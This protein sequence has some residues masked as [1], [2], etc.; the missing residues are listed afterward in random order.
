MLEELYKQTRYKRSTG[1]EYQMVYHWRRQDSELWALTRERIWK[2]DQGVCQSPS[3]APPKQHKLC[4]K[5]VLLKNCHIDHIQPLSSGGSNHARN[6]RTL[7]SVCHAL[8]LDR[9]HRALTTQQVSQ[10]RLPINWK[11]LTWM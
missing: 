3:G 2:R 5:T 11:H 10:G 4:S 6:L 1:L 9:K 8:R 7:C